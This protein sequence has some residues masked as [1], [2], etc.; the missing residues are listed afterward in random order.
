MRVGAL[1]PVRLA[2]S[3]LPGKALL[4]I[5]GRPMIA[6]LLDRVF[7]SRFLAARDVIVC[8]TEDPTDDR[9]VPVVESAGASVFRGSRDDLIDRF[10]KA[11]LR[12]GFDAVIQ[13][14]GDDPFADTGYMDRCLE[15]LREDT[16]LGIVTTVDLPL[17][18][19]SKAFRA[20]AAETVWRHH[21]SERNDTGFIYYF[22]RTGLCRVGHVYPASGGHRH[23]TARVT[24]DYPEDLLFFER[25]FDELQTGPRSEERRVGKE[26]R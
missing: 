8:T 18:L 3:R 2:S 23:A 20:S 10:H 1:I 11:I 16:S 24:L 5:G 13:V 9:L 25:L 19:G 7:A 26:C 4:P 6:H 17:G 21:L 12:F 15:L 22:T 14:D